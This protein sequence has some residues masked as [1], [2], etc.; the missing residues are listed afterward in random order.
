[1]ESQWRY[2]ETSSHPGNSFFF[3]AD[4]QTLVTFTQADQSFQLWNVNTGELQKIFTGLT[5]IALSPDGKTLA[6]TGNDKTI[7]LVDL[8]TGE[9]QNSLT[10]HSSKPDFIAFNPNGKTLVSRDYNS[11]ILWDLNTSQ[12]RIKVE[13]RSQSSC[14]PANNIIFSPSGKT[15]AISCSVQ[16]EDGSSYLQISLWNVEAAELI[17][18]YDHHFE[19]IAFSHD[20]KTLFISYRVSRV[21]SIGYGDG[22]TRGYTYHIEHTQRCNLT[23]GKID[24]FSSNYFCALSHDGQFFVGR[25]RLLE[26]NGQRYNRINIINTETGKYIQTLNGTAAALSPDGK[27]LAVVNNQVL[28]VFEFPSLTPITTLN[29]PIQTFC[30]S[31]DGNSLAILNDKTIKLFQKTTEPIITTQLHGDAYP[32]LRQLENLLAAELWDDADLETV[33]VINSFP[34][35]DLNVIDQLWIHYSNGHYGLSVQK[36]IWERII[37]GTIPKSTMN[38]SLLNDEEQF[39]YSIGWFKITSDAFLDSE[40]NQFLTENW[41]RA[42]EGY[43]PRKIYN[44]LRKKNNVSVIPEL[45]AQLGEVDIDPNTTNE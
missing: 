8:E 21:G 29:S 23:T 26:T 22:F 6:C 16:A 31:P 28:N 2:V 15:L 7:Q 41:D 34:T 4:G 13:A 30:F 1:M 27:I 35:Q 44:E 24:D 38:F 19:S 43:Y 25:N 42:R 20:E 17:G 11:I 32:H 3:S 40:F 37:D 5:T 36:Q 14:S 12:E 9:L 33:D 45:F 39:I 18:K 10:G